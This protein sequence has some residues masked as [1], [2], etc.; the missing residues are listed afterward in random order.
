MF[1]VVDDFLKR[2]PDRNP[3]RVY[4]PIS[5]EKPKANLYCNFFDKNDGG[6]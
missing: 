5:Y 1:S 4:Y 3:A 6:Y 2:K